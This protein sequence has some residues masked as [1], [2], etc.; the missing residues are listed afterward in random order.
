MSQSS[1]DVFPTVMHVAAA[2]AHRASARPGGRAP[3]RVDH[4]E[5][6]GVRRRREDRA[7]APDGRDAAH[8]RSGDERLGRAARVRGEEARRGEGGPAR[9]RARR[10][11]RRHRAQHASRVGDARRGGDRRAHRAPVSDRAEQ[12]RRA[13]R[14]RRHRRGERRDARA[15]DGVHEDRERR[16]PPRERPALRHRRADPPGERAGQLDHAGQGEPDAG[17]GADDG[18]GARDGQRRRRSASPARAGTSS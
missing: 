14:S 18:L 15:R 1:N 7:H 3:P 4:G 17:R 11:R 10:H 16:A 2:P 6:R 9:A 8:A 12:V 13:R 5:E